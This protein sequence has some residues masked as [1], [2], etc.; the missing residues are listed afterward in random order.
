VGEEARE[1]SPPPTRAPVLGQ[2]DTA[3]LLDAFD[4]A[5]GGHLAV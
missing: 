3:G 1:E 2:V 4:L 5:P